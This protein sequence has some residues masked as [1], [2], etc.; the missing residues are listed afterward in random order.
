MFSLRGL[1][2]WSRFTLIFMHKNIDEIYEVGRTS[3]AEGN[4]RSLMF[5]S[6]CDHGSAV[7]LIDDI[8]AVCF[9]LTPEPLTRQ[10]KKK[11][12]PTNSGL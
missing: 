9:P 12:V 10:E 2:W 1:G 6:D 11:A 3:G 8:S 7:S 4:L 5:S